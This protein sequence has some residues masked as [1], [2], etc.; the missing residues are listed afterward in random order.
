M[1]VED[2]DGRC[3]IKQDE[4]LLTRLK[5]VRQ[6]IYGAFILSHGSEEWLSVHIN[7]KEQ[8]AYLGY[9]PSGDGCHPGFVPNEMWNG[10]QRSVRFYQVNGDE[11]DS[12]EVSWWQLIPI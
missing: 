7:D 11:A 5:S 6:G 1:Y 8:A 9:F 3:D 10:E 12:L 4:E 2:I